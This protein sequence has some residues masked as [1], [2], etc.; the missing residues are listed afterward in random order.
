MLQNLTKYGK[1]E[2]NWI[3]EYGGKIEYIRE[4]GSLVKGISLPCRGRKV[5][6]RIRNKNTNSSNV[7]IR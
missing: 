5:V 7:I 4:R 1:F 6:V 3:C 2:K